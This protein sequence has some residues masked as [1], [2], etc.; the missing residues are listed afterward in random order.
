MKK[1]LL[2]SIATILLV[3]IIGVVHITTEQIAFWEALF[4]TEY[5]P[6]FKEQELTVPTD[7]NA[8]CVQENVDFKEGIYVVEDDSVTNIT[9]KEEKEKMIAYITYKM[10]N[11]KGADY[12]NRTGTPEYAYNARQEAIWSI[13]NEIEGKTIGD[14]HGDDGR[15]YRLVDTDAKKYQGGTTG[16]TSYEYSS[17]PGF[18]KLY[19]DAKDYATKS[20]QTA[21]VETASG[22]LLSENT[23]TTKITGPYRITFGADGELKNIL[24]GGS[25]SVSQESKDKVWICDEKGEP[26]Q[27]KSGEDFY[28]AIDTTKVDIAF[29]TAN[30]VTIDYTWNKYNLTVQ[31]TLRRKENATG[32]DQRI[33]YFEAEKEEKSTALTLN[34]PKIIPPIQVSFKK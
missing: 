19:S 4:G 3:F 34:L 11:E 26:K 14:T 33:A 7:G 8:A 29:A 31:E 5:T 10:I 1:K 18:V 22:N 24:L 17:A 28:I 13:M 25:V 21:K 23:D 12:A 27:I 30:K 32:E 9:G 16:P 15:Y 2:I 20:N 6:V